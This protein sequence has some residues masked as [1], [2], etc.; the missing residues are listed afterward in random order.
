MRGWRDLRPGAS[1]DSGAAQRGGRARATRWSWPGPAASRCA[2]GRACG[3]VAAARSCARPVPAHGWES[4]AA[5]LERQPDQYRES[6]DHARSTGSPASAARTRSFLVIVGMVR[7]PSNGGSLIGCEP[8]SASNF[9]RAPRCGHQ[10][11]QNLNSETS[12]TCP[13]IEPRI[14]ECGLGVALG[15]R[16]RSAVRTGHRRL[17]VAS[18]ARLRYVGEP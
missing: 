16:G 8:R 15:R 5:G 7:P 6:H 9:S 11:G 12:P 4:A 10:A 17:L 2:W 18:R 3:G 14:A 13:A 1:L